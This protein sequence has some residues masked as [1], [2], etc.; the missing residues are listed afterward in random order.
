MSDGV[1]V[2]FDKTTLEIST[3]AW[4]QAIVFLKE[5]KNK[6]SICIYDTFTFAKA[7]V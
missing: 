3:I 2:A 7:K 5:I 4:V 1:I 6:S